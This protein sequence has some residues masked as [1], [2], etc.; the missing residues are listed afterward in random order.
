MLGY[1]ENYK[2]NYY[3]RTQVWYSGDLE[4]LRL[5]AGRLAGLVGTHVQ[6][7]NVDFSYLPVWDDIGPQAVFVQNWVT[8]DEYSIAYS[9]R[10]SVRRIKYPAQSELKGV[11]PTALLWFGDFDEKSD[12]AIA[13]YAFQPTVQGLRPVYGETCLSVDFCITWQYWNK[14]ASGK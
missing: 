10:F 9:K 12:K 7:K 2:K 5:K 6:W 4:V 11:D 1:T 13:L 14:A 3:E 8:V